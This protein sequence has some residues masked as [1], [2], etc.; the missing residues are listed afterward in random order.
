MLILRDV[1]KRIGTHQVLRS[2]SARVPAG[3][4]L[5]LVG[6][7]GA[8]KTTLLRVIAGLERLDGGEI[9]WRD[10]VLAGAG[11]W[12]PPWQRRIGM[13][14]QDLALWPHLTVRQH[15]EFVQTGSIGRKGK[16]ERREAIDELLVQVGLE[17]LAHRYPAQL[18]GGQQQ[19][20]AM[21]R[22]FAGKPEILLLDEAFAHLDPSLEVQL[23]QLVLK[24]QRERGWTLLF[25]T[26]DTQQA[27]QYADRIVELRDGVLVACEPAAQRDNGQQAR[28][29]CGTAEYARS[30]S[31]GYSLPEKGVGPEPPSV[32]KGSPTYAR[33]PFWRPVEDGGS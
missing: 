31:A 6:L 23:W 7:S 33:L 14:F 5:A 11:R 4:R 32:G 2:V 10:K 30:A 24:R 28:T 15:L 29:G 21:A 17:A 25:V 18:S 1:E 3:S 12:V 27:T 13:V 9:L 22:A 19:R 8:G 26:H 16:K 20:L